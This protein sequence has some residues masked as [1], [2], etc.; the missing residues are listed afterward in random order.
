MSRP[1][2]VDVEGERERVQRAA[3]E[4]GSVPLA[5]WRKGW[6]RSQQ[7]EAECWVAF[8][9][10]QARRMLA[11]LN[12]IERD[13]VRRTMCAICFKN[14]KHGKFERCERLFHRQLCDSCHADSMRAYGKKNCRP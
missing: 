2:A 7:A 4:L 12:R 8:G 1:R 9:R 11:R 14:A 5:G 6:S 10:A 13:R 3:V